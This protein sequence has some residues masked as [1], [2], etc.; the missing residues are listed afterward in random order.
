MKPTDEEI[1]RMTTKQL[2]RYLRERD[3]S[4]QELPEVWDELRRREEGGSDAFYDKQDSATYELAR[5]VDDEGRVTVEQPPPWFAEA[6]KAARK[7][8]TQT[9]LAPVA[10]VA[11]RSR[12]RERRV[13][14]V[15]RAAPRRLTT[16]NPNPARGR[17]R[18]QKRRASK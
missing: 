16:T 15:A 8:R 1:D 4:R 13:R 7:E 17:G 12:A 9:A 11:P 14:L 3:P 10:K 6:M 5:M 2:R 18:S